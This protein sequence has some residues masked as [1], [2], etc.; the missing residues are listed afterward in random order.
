MNKKNNLIKELT[1]LRIALDDQWEFLG[2]VL[3]L[4]QELYKLFDHKAPKLFF[5]TFC[6]L[7][8]QKIEPVANKLKGIFDSLFPQS[9]ITKNMLLRDM[10]QQIFILIC[11]YRLERDIQE[12]ERWVNE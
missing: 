4:F 6:K 3:H 2:K 8:D 9:P 5:E 12:L 1:P 11:D 7:M 10:K